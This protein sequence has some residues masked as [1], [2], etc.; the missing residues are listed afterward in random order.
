[1]FKNTTVEINKL[2][3]AV[4]SRRTFPCPTPGMIDDPGGSGGDLLAMR[5]MA[6]RGASVA[7]RASFGGEM[8]RELSN[9]GRPVGEFTW[10]QRLKGK[11]WPYGAS[12]RYWVPR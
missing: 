7:V 6:R 8:V 9:R 3:D 4:R 10:R 12:E 2:T 5:R 11:Q 1:M